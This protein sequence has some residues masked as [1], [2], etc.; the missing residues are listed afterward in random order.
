MSLVVLFCFFCPSLVFGTLLYQN[1]WLQEEPTKSF[2]LSLLVCCIFFRGSIV[3]LSLVLGLHCPSQ[4][5]PVL[6]IF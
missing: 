4:P 2:I 5:C 1:I 3:V 6:S